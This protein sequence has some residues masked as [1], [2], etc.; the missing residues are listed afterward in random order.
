MEI[1]TQ[2]MS[3]V[4]TGNHRPASDIAWIGFAASENRAP[5]SIDA[6]RELFMNL[7]TRLD[8][9]CW[10]AK[11]LTGRDMDEQSRQTAKNIAMIADV[12]AIYADVRQAISSDQIKGDAENARLRAQLEA[13][14]ERNRVLVSR[15]RDLGGRVEA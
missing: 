5:P 4:N 12:D 8:E 2:A 6:I 14:Y 1:V 11:V 10:R 15:L 3:A 9:V 13:A 7:W